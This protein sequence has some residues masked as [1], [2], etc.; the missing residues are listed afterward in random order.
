MF[1]TLHALLAGLALLSS[2]QTAQAQNVS[3]DG[4][5]QWITYVQ[6]DGN[7][8]YLQDDRRPSLYTGDFGDCLGG[9]KT[10]DLSRFDAAYYKDNMTVLF[11]VQGTT[12][13]INTSLMM[14]IAV[15]AYG[16]S[17]FDL[18]VNPC[19]AN[20]ASLCPLNSSVPI[21][22]GAIIPVGES[23][24][25][26]IPNIALSIPDFEGEAILRI[27]SNETQSEIACY[28]AAITNGNSFSQPSSVGTVLGIFTLVALCASF[29]TAAYGEAVP[30]MR[31][32][33]AH[34]LSVGVIFAVFQHIYF[35]GALSLN[36]PPVL[37]AW[38]SN[39]AWA[40]GMIYSSSMQSSIDNLIGKH[41]G[42]TSQ[43]GAASS[44]SSQANLGGKVD[45]SLIYKR[46]LTSGINRAT[47]HPVLRD[48]ASEIYARPAGGL[49]KREVLARSIEQSVQR[50][51][52]ANAS[53]GYKWY[54]SPVPDGLPLPGNYSGFAGTLAKEGIATSN[55]FMT[56]LLW[57]LILFALLITAIITFKWTLEGL[58]H[59]K[60]IK[61]D[62]LK[63][64]RDHW[65]TYTRSLT[66]RIFYLA[67]FMMVFLTIFQ[68]TYSSPAGPRAIAA[69]VF[70]IFVVGVPALAFHA[71][72]NKKTREGNNSHSRFHVERK[73]LLGGKL[74]WFGVQ[75]TR[76]DTG[77]NYNEPPNSKHSSKPFWKRTAS[78]MSLTTEEVPAHDTYNVHDDE[79]FTMRFG[80]L[81]ARFRR[82][83]WWFFTA[84]LGYEF[85]RAVFYGGA[86]GSPLVQ[87]FGLLIIECLA[88]V[89]LFWAKPFEGRRLNALVIYCLGFSKIATLALSATLDVQ[90]NIQRI[91]TTAIGIIIIVIQ[92]IL[93][94][95]TMIAIVV[96]AISSYMSV[97]RN[98]EEFKPRRWANLREK[99]FDHLD[100]TVNDLP[101][102][103][104]I[105]KAPLVSAEPEEPRPPYFEMRT[106]RRVAKIEDE[107]EDFASEMR[108]EAN[109]SRMSLDGT[110]TRPRSMLRNSNATP[111]GRSRAPSVISMNQTNL[112]YGARPHRPSWSARDFQDV[113]RNFTPVDMSRT[114]SDEA[115]PATTGPSRPKSV[116][117]NAPSRSATLPNPKLRAPVS[118]EALQTGG[119]TSSRE[120]IGMVPAPTMRPRAGTGGS[121]PVSRNMT[122]VEGSHG[123]TEQLPDTPVA[124]RRNTGYQPLMTPAQEMDEWLPS[125]RP[126]NDQSGPSQ[127][128]SAEID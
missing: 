100:R 90:F 77:A 104:K 109:T 73:T 83:R 96:G 76:P 46:A 44:G 113:D 69:I 25:A 118:S 82:S 51:D 84:W 70:I 3:G 114:V 31:L 112:P 35:T 28:S 64:F 26:N 12:G 5:T 8:V 17:R 120:M 79:Q 56:G 93:T 92:G 24:V 103:P 58:A 86:S 126:S 43:I 107:D 14:Y 89:F 95:I 121:R 10:I 60:T 16:E 78:L 63:F 30:T 36:W 128:K 53:D 122:P 13:V 34:S 2:R 29:V 91:I 106:V 75:M 110:P 41:V 21:Q 47:N 115:L 4:S 27:F 15:Y 123:N 52:L 32:H 23:D 67:F 111:T 85:L 116:H 65:L 88:F 66:L 33:Y 80:W 19:Q 1:W 99:Y 71:V 72:L 22:G 48:M 81:A 98:R 101:P 39:F 124:S 108:P 87:V 40:S 37:V 45:L 20:I 94:I 119:E 102:E 9:D 127:W 97:S 117:I 62:R 61:Q 50:R 57:L 49:L 125:S 38:W 11:H 105:K 18:V 42:N 74:P 68:F 59:F 54:G 6:P 7:T 55:A